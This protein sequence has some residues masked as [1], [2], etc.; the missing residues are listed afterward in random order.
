MTR[1]LVYLAVVALGWIGC[2][3]EMIHFGPNGEYASEN[4]TPGAGPA[5]PGAPG[6]PYEAP[7]WEVCAEATGEAKL[8]GGGVDIIWFIDTSGSMREET[9][10]VQQNINAFAQFIGSHNLDYR[11]ILV[12]EEYDKNFLGFEEGICVPPPLG[13]PNC[14][15]GPRFRHIKTTVASTD[16][17]IKLINTY[18]KYKDFLRPGA[19]KNFV[20]VSDDNSSEPATWFDA[21]LAKLEGF[22]D[23]YLFHSIVAYGPDP[24]R[25]CATGARY[26]KVYEELSKQT[27]G[28]MFPVCLTDW[29][30][31]FDQLARSV[32]QNAK[33]PCAYD[34]PAAP[35]G[36]HI[37]PDQ[38]RVNY[39]ING[40]S[41][42]IPRVGSA[43][44]CGDTRSFHYDD[45]QDPTQVVF[46]PATCG[47][48][49]GG[50]IHITFGCLEIG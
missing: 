1:R 48:M 10:W 32:V 49:Q 5:A 30:P 6:S 29:N 15:D 20:A 28:A 34:L 8:V 13:G 46:C 3:G 45:N 42:P 37:K 41:I 44:E 7:A 35:P 21:E 17:L 14:T 27:G 38:I 43:A 36:E 31:I 11:V 4:G 50:K 16:G 40:Q 2:E 33:P 47:G 9:A 12:A 18:P 26:G 22:G 39:Q 25:G 23:G 19:T 24:K